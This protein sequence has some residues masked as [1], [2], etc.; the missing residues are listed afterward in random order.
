LVP[1]QEETRRE[2]ISRRIKEALDN[3]D[4]A[5]VALRLGIS[6]STI[7]DWTSGRFLPDIER[8]AQF[9]AITNTNISWLV[10]GRGAKRG[11]EAGADGY[12]LPAPLNV[13][14]PPLAFLEDWLLEIGRSGGA[15]TTDE[16]SLMAVADDSMEPALKRGDLLL[17]RR[18]TPPYGERNPLS[19]DSG[20][21][22]LAVVAR[23]GDRKLAPL[24]RFVV[25]RLQ[26]GL[27]GLITISCDNPAYKSETRKWKPKE[28]PLIMGQVIWRA[29]QI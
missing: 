8:L 11:N 9:A 29:S 7:Y 28:A 18:S 20:L 23:E 14:P 24:V 2:F 27:D 21:Y 17:V 25:R 19:G 16:L 3:Q 10:T 6:R 4:T 15:T 12:V 13:N 1:T 22:A 26:W 5:A